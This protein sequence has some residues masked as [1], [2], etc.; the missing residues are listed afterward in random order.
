[1]A[2]SLQLGLVFLLSELLL[3]LTH[4]RAA[5]TDCMRRTKRLVR[6]IY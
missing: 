1:M 5:D 2:L 6:F 3:T 4:R